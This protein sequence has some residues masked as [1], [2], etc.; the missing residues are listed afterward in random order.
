MEQWL[1]RRYQK[2]LTLVNSEEALRCGEF[3]DLMYVN[4]QN[5]QFDPTRQFAYLRGCP[6]GSVILVAVNFG[7]EAVMTDIRIPQHA[8][9]YMGLKPGRY[10]A[11]ELL[12]GL[13][14]EATL[15]PDLGFQ[16]E[17]RGYDAALWRITL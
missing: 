2:I 17:L 10:H 5:P 6:G 12:T 16:T 7:P 14:R 9:D 11:T 3:F 1:R 4:Q 8:F 15:F 13:E